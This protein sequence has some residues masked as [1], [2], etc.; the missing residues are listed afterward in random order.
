MHLVSP[1]I[2]ETDPDAIE[3]AEAY[4]AEAI[5]RQRSE[6]HRR[7]NLPLIAGK[8]RYELI[9]SLLARGV[10]DHDQIRAVLLATP[11]WMRFSQETGMRLSV[12]KRG[13]TLRPPRK[14]H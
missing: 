2:D 9:V 13:I 1:A 14:Q 5:M 8:P 7:Q 12:R 3:L 10:S 4:M 11:S 6:C